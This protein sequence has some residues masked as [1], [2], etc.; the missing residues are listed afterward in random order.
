VIRRELSLHDDEI[1]L[2]GMALGHADPEAIENTLVTERVPLA[3]NTTFL[4]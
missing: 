2:C 1:V 4:D 3:E